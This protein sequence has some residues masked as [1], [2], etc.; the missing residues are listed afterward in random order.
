MKSFAMRIRIWQYYTFLALLPLA[1]C[2]H[3][4]AIP[5]AVNFAYEVVNEDYSIPVEV[6]FE[7]KTTGAEHYQWTFEGGD[8]ETSDKYNP[9]PVRYTA[10]GT[11]TVHLEAWNGDDR[12]SKEITLQILGT[13]TPDFETSVATNSISPVQ[14]TLTNT[15]IGGTA[16]HWEF[17]EGVP[18][19]FTGHDPPVVEY[20]TPGEHRITLVVENGN[21]IDSIAKTITV[22]PALA[23]DFAIEPSFQDEDYEAPLTASLINSTIGGLTWQWTSTGGDIRQSTA[24]Q[25]SIHFAQPGTYSITLTAD[26][27]KVT[28]SINREIVVK[29]N[30]GLRTHHDIM[31]GINTAHSTVGSFYST[32][33][34]RVVHKDE[35]DSLD[36]YVDITFFGLNANFTFNRF[37]SPDSAQQYTFEALTQAQTTH[38]I[39]TQ[40]TCACGINFTEAEFDQMVTDAPLQNLT[41]TSR[42]TGLK[43]F[44]DSQVPRLVLFRTGDNRKGAIKIKEFHRDGLQSYIVVDIKIQKP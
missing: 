11:Y 15:T 16:Y 23:M 10:S 36:Q 5:A 21:E 33:L 37:V 14:V 18:T 17:P 12:Q 38:F 1:S 9:G 29:P 8:P 30:T 41:I 19:S 2:F 35:P 3:E 20:T 27:G 26:N 25:T 42:A 44:N 24:E 43:P 32:F 6:T 7:N 31:L 13:F 22:L 28:Q 40:E 39:N 4:E 34:R